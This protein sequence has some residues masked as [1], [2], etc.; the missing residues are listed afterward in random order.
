MLIVRTH[1]AQDDLHIFELAID[2]IMIIGFNCHN[3]LSVRGWFA[4]IKSVRVLIVTI[5]IVQGWF[6]H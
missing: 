1:V 4:D 6:L 5:F 3:I 2:G